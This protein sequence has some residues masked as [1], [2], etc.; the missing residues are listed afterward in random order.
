VNEIGTA[1]RT[2]DFAVIGAGGFQ[3]AKSVRQRVFPLV[4]GATEMKA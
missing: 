3:L 1:F 2:S 4:F